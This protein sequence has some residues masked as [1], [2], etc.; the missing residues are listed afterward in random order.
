MIAANDNVAMGAL[1]AFADRGYKVPEDFSMVSCDRFSGGNYSI[2]RMTGVERDPAQAGKLLTDCLFQDI[3]NKP[4]EKPARLIPR[5]V[6]KESC[7]AL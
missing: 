3:E 7:R 5:F 1:R 4:G 2:P 6:E